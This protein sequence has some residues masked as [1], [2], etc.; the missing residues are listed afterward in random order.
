LLGFWGTQSSTSI[1]TLG[2]ITIDV[3]RPYNFPSPVSNTSN[4]SSANVLVQ[5]TASGNNIFVIIGAS[6]GGA[7]FCI[8]VV[9]IILLVV[10]R[11][12]K[13]FKL[14]TINEEAKVLAT[15]ENG[16]VEI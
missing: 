15:L 11:N 6:V 5:N 16:P 14:Q 12:R 7:L 1:F 10:R 4:V 3:C 8:L 13:K 2:E 9:S